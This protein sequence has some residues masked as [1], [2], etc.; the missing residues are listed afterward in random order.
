[1]DF[2]SCVYVSGVLEDDEWWQ[3]Y[4]CSYQYHMQKEAQFLLSCLR[5]RARRFPF[6][7]SNGAEI[8]GPGKVVGPKQSEPAEQTKTLLRVLGFQFCS[9]IK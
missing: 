2:L 9:K 3:L 1:M 5:W 7:A 6:R 8:S 4:K